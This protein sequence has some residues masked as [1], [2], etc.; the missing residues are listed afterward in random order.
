MFFDADL[1]VSYSKQGAT[2]WVGEASPVAAFETSTNLKKPEMD[3]RESPTNHGR[4]D[5]VCLIEKGLGG[6][7]TWQLELDEAL[8][9]LKIGSHVQV[10]VRLGLDSSL[11]LAEFVNHLKSK[12]EITVYDIFQNQISDGTVIV[13]TDIVRHSTRP[14]A[15][16]I[17]FGVIT[18]GQRPGNVR[19]L[20]RSIEK[21]RN[22][23][24]VSL[25]II[26]C[27]PSEFKDQFSSESVSLKFLSQPPRR[28]IWAGLPR[29]RI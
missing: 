13:T 4:F 14:T 16:A 19:A 9:T 1:L 28:A 22:P 10:H 8:R 7:S 20:I 21:L 26:I 12:E 24:N 27:G 25:G 23:R 2:L 11:T 17:D 18:D 3:F 6:A 5:R 15:S 29:R